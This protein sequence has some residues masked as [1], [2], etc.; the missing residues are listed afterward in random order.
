M[1]TAVAREANTSIYNPSTSMLKCFPTNFQ[2]DVGK[3][4]NEAI[5]Y[6]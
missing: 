1:R 4:S 6:K 3:R 2:F 5:N